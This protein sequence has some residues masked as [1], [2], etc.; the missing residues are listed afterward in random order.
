MYIYAVDPT[1]NSIIDMD[2][3][4]RYL[5]FFI[6]SEKKNIVLT[7]NTFRALLLKESDIKHELPSYQILE[8]GGSSV[9]PVK[10]R[11]ALSALE[12]GVVSL[13]CIVFLGALTTAICIVC[14]RRTKRFR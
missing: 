11:Y 5:I 10:G 7:T 13:G 8:V 14:V 4:Q 9:L 3:L 1:S 2:T 12:L 6:Y